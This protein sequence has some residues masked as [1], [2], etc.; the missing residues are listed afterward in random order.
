MG[1][2]DKENSG[3]LS[4]GSMRGLSE[5][6]KR[7]SK[8]D[9]SYKSEEYLYSIKV[10]YKSSLDSKVIK[11]WSVGF[12]RLEIYSKFDTAMFPDILMDVGVPD[13]D[14]KNVQ[15]DY[16]NAII[17]ITIMR[18]VRKELNTYS[19]AIELW[20]KKEFR[21]IDLNSGSLPEDFT[22]KKPETAD[23][24][25]AFVPLRLTLISTE[26]L[27]VYKPLNNFILNNVTMADVLDFLIGKISPKG[28]LSAQ[29]PDNTEVYEQVFIPATNIF[30]T[31]E[32]LDDYYGIYTHGVT[33]FANVDDLII[34]S[35]AN[36]VVDQKAE[37]TEIDINLYQ[38]ETG[39]NE[40]SNGCTYINK[41][42]KRIDIFYGSI[43]PTFINDN[44][45]KLTTGSDITVGS[46]DSSALLKGGAGIQSDPLFDRQTY[47]WLNSSSKFR[48]KKLELSISESCEVIKIPIPG[49]LFDAFT[50]KMLVNVRALNEVA[51]D[52]KGKY[53]ISKNRTIF[54]ATKK[55]PDLRLDESNTSNKFVDA[56][57]TTVVSNLELLKIA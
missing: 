31:I 32:Y 54:Q 43:P 29:K 44:Y 6:R 7:N 14:L 33:V 16:R 26:T 48:D 19:G 56:H 28:I 12:N 55:N 23:M 18:S 46:R 51:Q 50:P 9:Q 5:Q 49:S 37:V 21:I 35:K 57:M 13:T 11:D 36:P 34:L 1:Y 20:S 25:T 4:S 42:D 53:R 40:G 52:Y 10:E 24:E 22:N 45:N 8:P 47:C 3:A 38:S 15:D 30:S 17:Y 27:R 41:E 2:Y 39:V